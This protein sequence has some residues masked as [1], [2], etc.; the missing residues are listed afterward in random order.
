PQPPRPAAPV[1]P[2]AGYALAARI[3]GETFS[4]LRW[5]APTPASEPVAPSPGLDGGPAALLSV[6]PR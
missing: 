3:Y 1:A 5:V 6:A 4:V 2:A